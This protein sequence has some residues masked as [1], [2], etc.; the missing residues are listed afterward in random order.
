MTA[1]DAL[2]FVR[3]HGVVLVSAQGPVPSLV[4]A[5]AREPV[6]GSWWSH[7]KGRLIF[8]VLGEVTDSPDILVCRL[9]GNKVT[10]VHK[11]LWP[12]LVRAAKRFPARQLAQVHQE[13]TPSGRHINRVIAFPKW[14]P[15]Q[16]VRKSKQMSEDAALDALGAWARSPDRKRERSR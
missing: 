6:R 11:R 13:H 2:A 3:R 16:C 7:P 1:R 5:I 12:A 8:A 15:A 14:A 10:L 9:V 4:E